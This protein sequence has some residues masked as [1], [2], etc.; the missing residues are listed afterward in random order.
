MSQQLILDLLPAPAPTLQNFI[1]GDNEE[2]LD[3]L[4]HCGPGRAIYL[5]GAPACGRTHL[6]R[7]FAAEPHGRYF[8]APRDAQTIRAM[9]LGACP[10]SGRVAVDDAH[11]L[12][13]AGQAAL[14]AL[15]NRWRETASTH[16]AFGL[17]VSGRQSPR[18][19]PLR[20][21]LRTRL[22]WDLVFRLHPLS[23]DERARAL[24]TQSAERGLMLPP[25]VLNWMLTHYDRDMTRLGALLDALDRYSVQTQRAV[26][27]PLLKTL[28]ASTRGLDPDQA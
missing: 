1:A 19:T 16:E 3:A 27:V 26:T 22:G 28:L 20:E 12:N 17:L 14:F 21:D 5:W 23:D 15:Y 13:D 18:A 25:E 9:A 24:Q 6:L 2:A 8:Q 10:A 4:R 11:L 7:A